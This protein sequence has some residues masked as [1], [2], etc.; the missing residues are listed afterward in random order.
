MTLTM[1]LSFL[2]ALVLNGK[3]LHLATTSHGILL[4]TTLVSIFILLRHLD[5]QFFIVKFVGKGN[6]GNRIQYTVT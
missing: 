5:Q 4:Y 2:H 3:P 6:S 1:E